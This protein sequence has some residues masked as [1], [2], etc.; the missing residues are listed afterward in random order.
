MIGIMPSSKQQ[1]LAGIVRRELLMGS[2]IILAGMRIY[3]P[4]LWLVPDL[5][6]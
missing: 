5:K 4:V 3:V 2:A 1:Y 6:S